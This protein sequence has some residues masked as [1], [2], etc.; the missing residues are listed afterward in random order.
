[1]Q[2]NCKEGMVEEGSLDHSGESGNA[3]E[4]LGGGSQGIT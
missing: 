3:Q 4:P 2:L 1:M